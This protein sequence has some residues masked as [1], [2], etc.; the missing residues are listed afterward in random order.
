LALWASR[1]V[2]SAER[3]WL[4]QSDYGESLC[5]TFPLQPPTEHEALADPDGV[6]AWLD[7]WRGF[8]GDEWAH[9]EWVE[10]RWPSLGV[11]RLPQRVHLRGAAAVER[12]AARANDWAH[13]RRQA[14]HLLAALGD[15]VRPAL[16]A[17]ARQLPALSAVELDQ[18]AA[19]VRWLVDHQESGLDR[20]ELPIPGIDSKWLERHR[21][22]VVPLVEAMG[23]QR[24]LGLKAT[25]RPFAVR[26]LDD[27]L[28]APPWEFAAPVAELARLDWRP[29][30][31]LISENLAPLRR[32]G[33]VPGAVAVH[34]QGY[35]VAELAGV[36]WVARA[37]RLLYWGDLDTHGLRILGQARRAWPN[38]ESVLMDPA[39]LERF[40][41]V[42]DRAGAEPSPFRGDIGYL[43]TA[44]TSAL[45]QLRSGDRRLEQERIDWDY[46]WGQVVEALG[47]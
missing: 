22:V 4:V 45:A 3:D 14:T 30:T 17:V 40:S 2:K 21:G 33:S 46:A 12:A 19:V 6:A 18:L 32:F 39:T 38:L 44:E 23:G 1:K 20:R 9:V 41:T 25:A 35:H 24:G 43:N 37:Q 15:S 26:V 7:S 13:L 16:R 27:S 28:A 5:F 47:V 34:G 10:R 8:P 31:V 11:Q 29:H 42:V 36:P